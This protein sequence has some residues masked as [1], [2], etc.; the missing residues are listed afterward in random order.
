MIRRLCRLRKDSSGITAVEFALISPILF[1][2][3]IVL[4][5]LGY[6]EYL[7]MMLQGALNEAARQ[8]TVGGLKPTDIQTFVQGRVASVSR[9]AVTSVKPYS[10]YD[11]TGIQTMEPITTD[12]NSNGQLDAGDC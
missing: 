3:M 11:F 4:A 2:I 6:R 1:M 10:F 8:A 5:D 9:Q 7:T 12:K